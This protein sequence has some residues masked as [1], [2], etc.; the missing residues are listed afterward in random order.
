MTQHVVVKGPY[1]PVGFALAG[2]P[3]ACAG[4]DWAVI[5]DGQSLYDVLWDRVKPPKVREVQEV[6]REVLSS[7]GKKTYRVVL[8][9]DGA[10]SCECSG[11]TYRRHCRHL[12]ELK[13]EL[14]W[15]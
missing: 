11:F 7:T 2:T 6:V 5:P 13:K 14:G 4:G 3:Y 9:S 10:R 8:R 12:D 1:P 15:K